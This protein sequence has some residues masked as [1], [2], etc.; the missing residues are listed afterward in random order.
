MSPNPLQLLMV[1]KTVS[2]ATFT[3]WHSMKAVA[4]PVAVQVHKKQ[5]TVGLQ[6]RCIRQHDQ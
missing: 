4:V 6:V 5:A 1:R 2:P 3:D